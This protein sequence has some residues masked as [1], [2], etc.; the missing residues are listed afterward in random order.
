MRTERKAKEYGVNR[1]YQAYYV[2]DHPCPYCPQNSH[3]YGYTTTEQHQLWKIAH[4]L[5]HLI[6]MTA[7]T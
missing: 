2:E 3:G 1:T 7:R 4:L 6:E 5:W